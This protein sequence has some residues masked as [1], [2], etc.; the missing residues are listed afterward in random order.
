MADVA[1][2]QEF[3]ASWLLAPGSGWPLHRGHSDPR[4]LFLQVPVGQVE[5]IEGEEGLDPL[6][7]LAMRA[8]DGG[9]P[10]G[11]DNQGLGLLPFLLDTLD[12]AINGVDGAEKDAAV[13]T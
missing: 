13:Q 6:D 9:K 8:D 3:R 1:F 5:P 11:G 4:V 2:R 10:A 12:H 7:G